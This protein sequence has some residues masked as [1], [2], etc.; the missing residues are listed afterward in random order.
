MRVRSKITSAMIGL[1]AM[2][3]VTLPAVTAAS[4]ASATTC[5]QSPSDPSVHAIVIYNCGT[6]QKVVMLWGP[7]YTGQIEV[8][9]HDHP[10]TTAHWSDSGYWTTGD[11]WTVNVSYRHSCAKMMAYDSSGVWYQFGHIECAFAP[12]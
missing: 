10:N 8:W 12:G 11:Y 3:A 1:A 9:D 4:P 7:L 6:Y 2:A 5:G